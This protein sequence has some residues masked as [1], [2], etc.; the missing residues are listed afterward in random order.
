MYTVTCSPWSDT[1]NHDDRVRVWRGLQ[2]GMKGG[3][4]S[5]C[6]A[7][8]VLANSCSQRYSISTVEPTITVPF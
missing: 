5:D 8:A 3:T 2:S 7:E 6:N 4:T 1:L